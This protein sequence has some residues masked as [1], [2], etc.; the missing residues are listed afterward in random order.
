MLASVAPVGAPPTPRL[1]RMSMSEP[2]G[3]AGVAPRLLPDAGPIPSNGVLLH[4]GVHKT[5]TTAIQAALADARPELK[6]AGIAYPGKSAAHHAEAFAVLQKPWGWSA[7][8]GS[9]VSPARFDRL[10]ARVS[11]HAG[12][13]VVSS[14]YFCEVDDQ[15]AAR[16]VRELGGDRVE[17]VV[18]LRNLGRM[19]PSSWQQYL[20][21]GR[22]LSYSRWLKDVLG[23]PGG[24]NA[25][26]T[27]WRRHDHGAVVERWSEV[28][29]P[30]KVTVLVLED[31]DRSALFHAFAQLLELPPEVLVSRK[32]LTSNRS[33]TASEAEL[34]V[35][36]NKQVRKQLEWDDYVRLVRRGVA[37]AMVEGRQPADDEPRL[38]TPQWALDAAAERGQQS[39]GTIRGL[40]VTVLGDLEALSERLES[41]PVAEKGAATML[42]VDAAVLALVNVIGLQP[43]NLTSRELAGQLW[44]HTKAR[45]RTTLRRGDAPT[46]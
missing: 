6:A 41:G 44:R 17:V 19:L 13:A 15:S 9:L 46:S 10:A 33:M 14:E 43:Q 42:P 4:I 7:R 22:T 35:R 1:W 38:R 2:G 30:E 3:R 36:L 24:R 29:G 8:G 37:Q 20:K 23:G 26:P 27:F 11:G 12:R 40:G 34:L 32:D 25:T 16:V 21:Y 28:V 45:G 5:G 39:V 18:T 31:V